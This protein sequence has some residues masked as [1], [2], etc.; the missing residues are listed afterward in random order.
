MPRADPRA[1]FEG[2]RGL[3]DAKRDEEGTLWGGKEEG[4]GHGTGDSQA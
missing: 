1:A 2:E 4:R 3:K